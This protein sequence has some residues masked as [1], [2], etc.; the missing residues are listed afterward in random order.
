MA[1]RLAPL[2]TC[3]VPV[4]PLATQTTHIGGRFDTEAGREEDG[5]V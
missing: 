2:Q 1:A 4:D 5:L 3:V